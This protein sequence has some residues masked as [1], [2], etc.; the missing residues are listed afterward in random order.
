MH[1]NHKISKI[2]PLNIAKVY[3]PYAHMLRSFEK[4]NVKID[5][6]INMKRTANISENV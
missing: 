6:H 5:R 4:R 2:R 1:I 3:Y